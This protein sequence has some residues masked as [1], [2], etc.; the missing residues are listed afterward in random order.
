MGVEGVVLLV[1][2]EGGGYEEVAYT[3]RS[4]ENFYLDRKGIVFVVAVGVTG[5]AACLGF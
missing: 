2:P 3:P 1:A 5:E 4:K